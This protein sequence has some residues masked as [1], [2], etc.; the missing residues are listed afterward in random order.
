M[1]RGCNIISTMEKTAVR[2]SFQKSKQ[3]RSNKTV[4]LVLTDYAINQVCFPL[5]HVVGFR[6]RE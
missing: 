3:T 4:R 6:D 5:M 1:R 2:K